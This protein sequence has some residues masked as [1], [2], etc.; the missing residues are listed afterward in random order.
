M[1]M[2]HLQHTIRQWKGFQLGDGGVAAFDDKGF[3]AAAQDAASAGGLQRRF[4][5]AGIIHCV[6]AMAAAHVV[7]LISE[8]NESAVISVIS[9]V[10]KASFAIGLDRAVIR[11]HKGIVRIAVLI[12][13]QHD[14]HAV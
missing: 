10:D 4:V 2:L 8:R 1:L 7:F 14:R 11:K 5:I 6:R 3:A 9:N 12:Q 13:G